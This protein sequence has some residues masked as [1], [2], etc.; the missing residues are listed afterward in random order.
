VQLPTALCKVFT[1][2][3]PIAVNARETTTKRTS[4]IFTTTQKWRIGTQNQ[5]G[6]ICHYQKIQI[7]ALKNHIGTDLIGPQIAQEPKVLIQ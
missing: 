1:C 4:K 3:F 2:Y 7:G 5:M 6:K